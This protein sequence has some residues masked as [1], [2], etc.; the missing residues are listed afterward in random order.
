MVSWHGALL[1]ETSYSYLETL[2]LLFKVCFGALSVI[3][4]SPLSL[5]S[6]VTEDFNPPLWEV[7]MLLPSLCSQDYSKQLG[8]NGSQWLVSREALL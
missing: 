7:M 2:R 5:S 6:L 4:T 8:P 1:M 3:P